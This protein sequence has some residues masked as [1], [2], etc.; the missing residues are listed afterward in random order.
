MISNMHPFSCS[1][2][3]GII[4]G[5]YPIFV[6]ILILV[7]CREQIY[8]LT[9]LF[10]LVFFQIFFIL[11]SLTAYFFFILLHQSTEFGRDYHKSLIIKNF[12]LIIILIM[13]CLTIYNLII[14]RNGRRPPAIPFTA[15]YHSH[16]I[17]T[18]TEN[19]E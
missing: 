7:L 10:I 16:Q 11:L 1:L 12:G 9:S 2:L 3:T 4:N 5:L 8:V 17:M 18:P 19:V 6:G 15:I 14:I 13:L